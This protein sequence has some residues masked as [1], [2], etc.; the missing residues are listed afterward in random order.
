MPSLEG[1]M[2][3]EAGETKEPEA[4]EAESAEAVTS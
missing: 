2:L 3:A 1:K 4:D